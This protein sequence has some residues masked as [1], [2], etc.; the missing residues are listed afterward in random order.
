MVRLPASVTILFAAVSSLW[1]PVFGAPPPQVQWELDLGAKA[2]DSTPAVAPDGTVYVGSFDSALWAI[3]T[4]GEAGWFFRPEGEIRSSPAVALDGTVLFGCRDK[5]LYAVTSTGKKRWD[6]L[7]GGWVDSSPALARDGTIYFGS[8]DGNFYAL[9]AN[10]VLKWKVAAGGI[11]DSSPVI[12]IDGTVFCGSHGKA[13]F[14]FTPQGHELWRFQTE[15]AIISSPALDAHGNICFSALD[16]YLYSVDP[17]GE[18]RWRLKTGDVTEASPVISA[19]GTIY[20][21]ANRELWAVTA[22]GS[23]IWAVRME[24]PIRSSATVVEGGMIYVRDWH[25]LLRSVSPSGKFQWEFYAD[26]FSLGSPVAASDGTIYSPGK[27]NSF[28]GLSGSWPLE[29]AAWPKF[30][31]NPRNTGNLQDSGL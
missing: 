29:R 16:G 5:K 13:L 6:Y 30:R 14:A 15:G 18:L 26:N 7:T 10:G 19:D 4:N 2:I 25:G 9:D 8:W 3:R 12:G 21:A 27:Y 24:S 22:S 11:I 1:L 23:K 28:L 17:G 31:G 20:A